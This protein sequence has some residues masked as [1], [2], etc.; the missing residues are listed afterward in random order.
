MLPSFCLFAF[1][2]QGAPYPSDERNAIDAVMQFA[3]QELKFQPENIVLF[4]WSI[5]GYTA[6]YAAMSYPDIK[7]VV[8]Y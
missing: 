2:V 3:I 4:A 7:H 6:T 8:I 5:G 1:Y